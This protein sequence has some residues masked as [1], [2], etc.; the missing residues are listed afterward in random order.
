MVPLDRYIRDG[1]PLPLLD[2]ERD[3]L[4]GL[5]RRKG[6]VD[7][8]TSVALL[9]ILATEEVGELPDRL[10][11][12][13]LPFRPGGPRVTSYLLGGRPLDRED[14]DRPRED[15]VGSG[16]KALLGVVPATCCRYGLPGFSFAA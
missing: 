12:G 9:L 10:L 11:V 8:G 1:V 16:G 14:E 13:R 5:G 2:P 7:L 15:R 3:P 6:H 4:L